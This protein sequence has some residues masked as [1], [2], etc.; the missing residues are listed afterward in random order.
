MLLDLLVR[1]DARDHTTR[2]HRYHDLALHLSRACISLD[3]VT[4]ASELDFLEVFR[5]R[6]SSAS[7]QP[8]YLGPDKP[9]N[10]QR[11]TPHR[12]PMSTS[13][14]PKQAAPSPTAAP[15]VEPVLG[16]MRTIG[17]LTAELDELV[18]LHAVKDELHRL[19][20]LLQIQQLRNEPRAANARNQ[21]PSGI[22]R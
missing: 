9:A 22:Y 4:S 13:T 5:T 18:G 1:A 6:C 10:Q 15:A 19:T 17:E 20:S 14:A 7:T 2:S 16:P 12:A 3:L 21:P 8:E 11:P